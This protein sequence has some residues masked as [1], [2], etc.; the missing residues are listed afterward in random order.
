MA[1]VQ[2]RFAYLT[3]QLGEVPRLAR[4]VVTLEAAM[5]ATRGKEL[6]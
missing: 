4:R 6:L 3:R 1:T 5:K 2:P